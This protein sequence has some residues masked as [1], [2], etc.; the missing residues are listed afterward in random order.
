MDERECLI[1]GG[2]PAG[3]VAAIR[4]HQLGVKATLVEKDALGGTCL[5][6]GCIPTRALVRGVELLRLPAKAKEFGINYQVPEVNFQ[7][8]MERKD[9][10]IK[11]I[12]GGVRDLLC[13]NG[14]EVIK[15]E[16]KLTSST[17]IQVSEE[18]MT[19]HFKSNKILI[20]AGI[21]HQK[22]N[23]PG[24]N[25][26][27][28]ISEA[29]ALKA[30]PESMLILGAGSIG[31]TYAVIFARLGSQVTV[32]EESTQ[33]LKGFD[34]ELVG[35]LEREIRKEKVKIITEATLKEV[36]EE[37]AI[38]AIKS[39]SE[40]VSTKCVLAA[41]MKVATDA[42]G[43]GLENAGITVINGHIKV[44]NHLETNVPGIY[45]AGDVAGGPMLAHAAFIGG[46]IVAENVAGKNSSIDFNTIPSC[47]Y[48]FP[49]IATV[50]LTEEEAI[51]R[52]N[53]VRIGRFPFSANGL[54]TINGERNGLVK[55]VT[56]TK[57]EQILGVHILGHSASELISE[58]VLAMRL[59]EP[60]R[61]IGSTIHLHP[62]L[63]EAL[64]E[65]ALD[66]NGE[67][68]HFVSKNQRV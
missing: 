42:V 68:I 2:G 60:A 50:G 11:T 44:D 57:Y 36:Q 4:A 51:A 67:T 66:V 13:E 25:S 52:G 23:V 14:I 3:Y 7:K 6:R 62:T 24:A 43:L 1:I 30:I 17:E 61:V 56:E 27:I 37:T 28:T 41:D 38:V 10:I 58:A 31:I 8:M 45:A 40:N 65:A 47:I 59:E 64:M 53:T 39:V 26:I 46:R 32:I 5:N 33:I 16:A 15:G 20:A 35:L 48:T 18:S 19:R 22:P 29:L 55:I 9:T 49:E 12:G 63:S 54:A 34:R 21:K